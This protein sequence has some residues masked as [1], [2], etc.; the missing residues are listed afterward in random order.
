MR[1]ARSAARAVLAVLLSLGIAAA[2]TALATHSFTNSAVGSHPFTLRHEGAT[3]TVDLSAIAGARVFRATLDPYVEPKQSRAAY[4]LRDARGRSLRLLPP[5]YRTFDA[6]DAVAADLASGKLTLTIV[7][8]GQGFGATLSLDVLCD[9]PSPQPVPQVSDVRAHCRDGDTMIT[10]REVEPPHLE[11]RWTI[12]EHRAAR[13]AMAASRSPK[14]RYRIYR[15]PVPFDRPEAIAEAELIDEIAPASG[16]NWR[17]PGHDPK[18]DSRDGETIEPLPVDD[19]RLAAPGTGI[20]VHKCRRAEPATAYYLASHTW[21]GSEDFAGVRVDG[22][23]TGPVR[24]AAGA[25]LTLLRRRERVAGPWGDHPHL[26]MTLEYY[27]RWASTPEWNTP[28]EA[29]DYRLGIPDRRP[30]QPPLE[31][32]PHAWAGDLSLPS[33]WAL[34][35]QGSLMVTANLHVYNSYTGFHECMGTL[36]SYDDG[37]VQP[38]FQARLLDF[39]FGFVYPKHR[40]DENRMYLT[41]SSMGGAASHYWGLRSGHLFAAVSA[42]VGNPIPAEDLTREFESIGEW[43]PIA[44]QSRYSNLQLVRFGYPPVRPADGYVVWDYFDTAKWLRRFPAL[45]TPYLSMANAP[46]DSLIAWS[47]VWKTVRALQASRRPFVFTWSERGHDQRAEPHPALVQRDQSLPAFSRCSLDDDLGAQPTSSP[48]RG[49]WNRFL[50]WN[51]ATT[52]D[53]SDLWET[54]VHLDRAAPAPLCTANVTPRRVRLFPIAA[55]RAFTCLLFEGGRLLARKR[56]RADADGVL[57]VPGIEVSQIPRRLSLVEYT[58]GALVATARLP[59]HAGSPRADPHLARTNRLHVLALSA[60]APDAPTGAATLARDWRSTVTLPI[61]C[62]TN[63][64]MLTTWVGDVEQGVAALAKAT[65]LRSEPWRIGLTPVIASFSLLEN[66]DAAARWEKADAADDDVA[67]G[68]SVLWWGLV[69]VV[70]LA[71]AAVCR[72]RA[73]ARGAC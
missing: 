63:A 56:V 73:H 27:V 51:A 9:R 41:G 54:E 69:P 45:D 62:G 6:T 26:D 14:R 37:T 21:N 64:A 66:G 50:R 59:M 58:G 25:G 39:V 61:G 67:G 48:A 49:Q 34:Y 47:P 11:P 44:W 13:A 22:N 15:S 55:N 46:N 5:R 2:Q 70:V 53:R 72:R 3:I 19:L 30:A 31:I 20:Y 24:E 17:L 43:G 65:P 60:A 52:I 32:V 68:G 8:A 35:A 71:A 40:F 38:F 12:G 18:G 28:S 36:R 23:A 42:S 1:R 7:S 57:T 16:W 33:A 10:F 29:F 4:D